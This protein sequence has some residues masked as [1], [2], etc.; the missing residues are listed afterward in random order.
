M[1]L[2]L[3]DQLQIFSQLYLIELLEFLTGQGLLE[4]WHL[5][6]SRLDRVWHADLLHKLKSYGISSQIFGLISSFLRST[7]KSCLFPVNRTVETK[8]SHEPP[9]VETFFSQSF[10]LKRY[11]T[12]R[13]KK[14][15]SW[16]CK[17]FTLYIF[18]F[19]FHV[20]LLCWFIIFW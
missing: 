2:G 8:K 19:N 9:R 4:L 3:I 1:V 10:C 15:S 7:W 12:K 14:I 18:I 6:C 20:Q 13:F 16:Y 5:I 17:N 11:M